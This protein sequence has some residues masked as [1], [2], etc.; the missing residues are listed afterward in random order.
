VSITPLTGGGRYQ[1][2]RWPVVGGISDTADHWWAVSMSSLATGQRCHWY[3]PPVWQIQKISSGFVST[4]Q[5]IRCR[6]QP[7]SN[8]IIPQWHCWPVMGIVSD[9]ADL[10]WLLSV[11]LRI[12]LCKLCSITQRCHWHRWPLIRGIYDIADRW[13]AVSRIPLTGCELSGV[14]N[15]DDQWWLLSMPPL[16][17][18]LKVWYALAAFKGNSYQNN[19]YRQIVL[20]V[21]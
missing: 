2:H 21:I 13:W 12:Q 6:I 11:T 7:Q 5:K 18:G 1:W 16:T 3:R 14:N 4:P 10:S 15:F 17:K 20:H 9:A 8:Y 19:I